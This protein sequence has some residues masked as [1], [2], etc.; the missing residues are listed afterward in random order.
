[1]GFMQNGEISRVFSFRMDWVEVGYPP[2]WQGTG[3]FR[4]ITASFA[5]R[6]GNCYATIPFRKM[7]YPRIGIVCGGALFKT[8][9][10]CNAGTAPILAVSRA[11]W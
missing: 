11:P 3:G 6:H 1:M 5:E 7:G 10:N 8:T 2:P 9:N 4:G